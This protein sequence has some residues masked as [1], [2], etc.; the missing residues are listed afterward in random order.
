MLRKILKWTGLVILLA[1]VSVGLATAS[2]QHLTYD[3]P[4][5]DI[6]AS[7]DS[8]VIAKGKNIALVTKGC[9]YCTV[10]STTLIRY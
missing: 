9:V 4:Y 1:I 3:A 7:A 5:P 2:R 8:A 10:Q 6:K